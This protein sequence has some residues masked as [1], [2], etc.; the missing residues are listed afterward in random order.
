MFL[1]AIVRKILDVYWAT[2]QLWFWITIPSSDCTC[3]R[4]FN[5]KC[6]ISPFYSTW[7]KPTQHLQVCY[8]KTITILVYQEMVSL[9]FIFWILSKCTKILNFQWWSTV[10]LFNHISFFVPISWHAVYSTVMYI[11]NHYFQ[12]I[13][14]INKKYIT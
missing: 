5:W 6:H 1:N 14:N 10:K 12:N 3:V 2:K 4:H 11:L 7:I 8:V 9:I 13:W